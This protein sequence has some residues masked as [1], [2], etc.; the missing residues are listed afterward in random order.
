MEQLWHYIYDEFKLSS[1][2]QPVLLTEPP[3]NPLENKKTAVK[4]FLDSFSSPG[5]CI[6][7]QAILSLYSLG[8]TTGAMLDCG[9][10]VCHAVP[11]YDGFS[12]SNCVDRIDFAGRD[13]TEY[14]QSM[15]RRS[16]YGF[17]TS[18]KYLYSLNL[19]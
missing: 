1:Q 3:L 7:S 4:I 17:N 15:L 18:V 6:C 5:I 11:I 16:G 12:I 14:L 8:K 10:G 9:D 19:K 13:V 2:D